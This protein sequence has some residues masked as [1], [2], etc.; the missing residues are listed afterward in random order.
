MQSARNGKE[1]DGSFEELHVHISADSFEKVDAAVA[2][3]E[4]LLTPV[5]VRQIK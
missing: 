5:D 3:I 4:P 1:I 2:I